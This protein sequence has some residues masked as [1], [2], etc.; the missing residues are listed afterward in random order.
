MDWGRYRW[1]ITRFYH[2]PKDSTQV[3]GSF[4]GP[5]LPH[6]EIPRLGVLTGAIA[7]GLRH[8][9]SNTR[10]EPHLQPTPQLTATLY[11]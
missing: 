3:A 4:F 10:S 11:P 9:H 8:S 7:A 5:Y 1:E 2:N 6:T